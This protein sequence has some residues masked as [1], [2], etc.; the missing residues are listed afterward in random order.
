MSN[1]PLS[2]KA[3]DR[4][5][6]EKELSAVLKQQKAAAL[7][8][9]PAYADLL[10]HVQELV[11]RGGKRVRPYLVELAYKGYGGRQLSKI[12]KVAASQELFHAFILMHDDIIDRDYVRWGGPNITGHY[13]QYFEKFVNPTEAAH[14]ASSWGL[15][16]GDACLGIS[17][18]LLS[19]SGFAATKNLAALSMVQQ[20]L[21]AMIGGELVDTVLPI[22]TKPGQTVDQERILAVCQYKTSTYSFCTPLQLGALFAG[23]DSK[24]ITLLEEFGH[25]LGIAYQLRDDV[26][27]VYC[28]EQTL[29][30]PTASDLVEGKQTILLQYGL[31]L[32][33]PADRKTLVRSLKSAK[34]TSVQLATVQDIL[35]RSG[36]RAK[37]EALMNHFCQKALLI[38]DRTNL[39]TDSKVALQELVTY[40]AERPC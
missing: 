17:N 30:K 31:A 28:D 11:S 37:T 7:T 13:Q 12:R 16:A 34:L 24:E 9:D 32:C 39:S 35:V 38:L 8:I 29:G 20:T 26:L 10:L 40:C 36:A 19:E 5:L 14:Y 4:R 15:L 6:I 21:F 1:L 33:S 2:L 25:A 27:D 3:W 18:K 23:A 22:V